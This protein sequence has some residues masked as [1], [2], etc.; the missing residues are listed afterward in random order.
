MPAPDDAQDD[1][2][3][4]LLKRAIAFN[5]LFVRVVVAVSVASA[6]AILAFNMQ[7]ARGFG[8]VSGIFLGIWCFVWF[9]L[10]L[11]VGLTIGYRLRRRIVTMRVKRWCKEA[12]AAHKL[13]PDSFDYLVAMFA[14]AKSTR[15][16]GPASRPSP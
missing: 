2:H 10:V 1:L 15:E 16:F 11:I 7:S 3:A 4:A 9:S 13:P 6:T 8:I 5:T 14:N 12:I